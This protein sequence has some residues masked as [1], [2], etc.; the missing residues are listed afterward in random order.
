MP[1]VN[2]ALKLEC[3]I[4]EQLFSNLQVVCRL[5]YNSRLFFMKEN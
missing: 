3:L 4:F 5:S 2:T 1:P